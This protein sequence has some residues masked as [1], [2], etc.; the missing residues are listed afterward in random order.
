LERK[1]ADAKRALAEREQ[2]LC[3]KAVQARAHT[4]S[5]L[6]KNLWSAIAIVAGIGFLFGLLQRR[7]RR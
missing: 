5:Y 7:D 4:E 1:T 2:A 3:E 6:C